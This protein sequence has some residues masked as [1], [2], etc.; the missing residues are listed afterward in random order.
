MTKASDEYF[1]T[2]ANV[3]E[4]E[5]ALRDAVHRNYP[6][7]ALTRLSRLLIK[8]VSDRAIARRALSLEETRAITE[9]KGK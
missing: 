6:A 8:A 4:A 2:A 1:K 9:R 3:L 5:Q 7:E